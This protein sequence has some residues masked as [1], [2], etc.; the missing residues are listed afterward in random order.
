MR[1]AFLR[2]SS[3]RQKVVVLLTVVLLLIAA[4]VG[5]V[6]LF[7]DDQQD[8]ATAINAAGKQRLLVQ[9]M[10]LSVHLLAMDG[11]GRL[12]YRYVGNLEWEPVARKEADPALAA[13]A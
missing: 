9:Q 1:L 5:G 6:W 2:R 7:L 12:A 10:R 8:D 4:H 11:E 13:A 3:N